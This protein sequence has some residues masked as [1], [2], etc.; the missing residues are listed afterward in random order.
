MAVGKVGAFPSNNPVRLSL[1]LGGIRERN[2]E[3]FSSFRLV[4]T[5]LILE[6]LVLQA[7]VLLYIVVSTLNLQPHFHLFLDLRSQILL[8]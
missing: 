4:M 1:I 6:P 7:D 3:T 8:L 5:S 2:R